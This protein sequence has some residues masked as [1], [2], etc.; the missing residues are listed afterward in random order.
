[1]CADSSA[2]AL[3]PIA[4]V[5]VT[6]EEADA[7]A[8]LGLPNGRSPARR[9]R[10][11]PAAGGPVPFAARHASLRLVGGGYTSVAISRSA[12][13]H[14]QPTLRRTMLMNSKPR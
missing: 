7:V 9:I 10:T 8:G 3:L 14:I 1:M 12:F 11:K 4:G 6:T 5:P 13:F 2:G